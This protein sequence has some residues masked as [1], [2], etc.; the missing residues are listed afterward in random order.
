[1]LNTYP[2]FTETVAGTL[3]NTSLTDMMPNTSPAVFPG[4]EVTDHSSDVLDLK[5]PDEENIKKC[6][7]DDDDEEEEEEDEED[8]DDVEE[9]DEDDLE[10]VIGSIRNL[11][12]TDEQ[13]EEDEEDSELKIQ[14]AMEAEM[15]MRQ[16]EQQE[17]VLINNVAVKI[18]PK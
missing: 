18:E 4:L 2:S 11:D 12:D 13:T 17:Q 15:I 1:M 7:D 16:E 6:F 5:M 14:A 9:I 10:E 3:S 8:Y